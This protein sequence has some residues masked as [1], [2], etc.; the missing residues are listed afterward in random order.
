MNMDPITTRTAT[1][2]DLDI[3]LRFEQGL[4]EAER[5]MD[6]T[7]QDGPIHYYDLPAM[8]AAPHIEVIVATRGTKV[9]G[10][11]YARIEKGRH[12]L[13]H[14][15]HAYCGFMYVDPEYRGQGI[16]QV[17]IAALK[18]WVA[19]QQVT[20]MVLEVY[21]SNHNAVRA[22]EKAGF[23]HHLYQMRLPLQDDKGRE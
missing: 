3:L 16:N 13:K 9:I 5:P 2:D 10:C 12:Y 22:Y 14:Q 18:R 8:L 7:I 6:P 1:P 17:I 19:S 21:V 4:I 11:A 20:E 15:H 23:V